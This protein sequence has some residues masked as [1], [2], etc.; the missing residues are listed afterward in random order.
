[1]CLNGT[2]PFLSVTLVRK[3]PYYLFRE[4]CFMDS[5]PLSTFF[6]GIY[7]VLIVFRVDLKVA[8]GMI[9][10]RANLRR[11]FAYD[12]MTAVAAL[13]DLDGTL[14]KDLGGFHIAQQ[15]TVAFLVVLFNGCHQAEPFCQLRESLGFGG[16]GKAIIHIRP[17]VVFT[18]GGSQKRWSRCRSVP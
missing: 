12:D 7:G 16:F 18:L 9:A 11:F 14:G 5:Y 15:R 10:G 17:L 8:L 1:M 4:T 13:P 6:D 3:L 2:Y